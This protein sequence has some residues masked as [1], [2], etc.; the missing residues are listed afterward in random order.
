[1]LCEVQGEI[2]DFMQNWAKVSRA[3]QRFL[4]MLSTTLKYVMKGRPVQEDLG[5][6]SQRIEPQCLG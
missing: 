2:T 6:N 1:M 4:Q 5:K 3:A